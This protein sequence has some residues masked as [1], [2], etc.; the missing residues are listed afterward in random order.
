M[1]PEKK[2]KIEIEVPESVALEIHAHC[3]GVYR[4][5]KSATPELKEGA[6]KVADY[7][8]PLLYLSKKR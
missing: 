3:V 8:Y 5:S 1:K 6:G 7:L 4:Y 2:I